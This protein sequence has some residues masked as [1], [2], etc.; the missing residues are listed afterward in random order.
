[1]TTH[2][3]DISPREVLHT[4]QQSST[5]PTMKSRDGRRQPLVLAHSNTFSPPP[6]CRRRSHHVK[7]RID[8]DYL[9]GNYTRRLFRLIFSS[10]VVSLQ[11]NRGSLGPR[12]AMSPT[13]LSDSQPLN[14]LR[15]PEHRLEN[16][17]RAPCVA[18][19]DKATNGRAFVLV[20]GRCQRPGSPISTR[21]EYMQPPV[22]GRRPPTTFPSTILEAISDR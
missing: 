3:P 1:M 4:E 16:A 12:N 22:A 20:H 13:S 8:I 21:P 17:R 7:G 14:M 9:V 11:S 5:W 18:S 15:S 19:L 10:P 2:A 6:V